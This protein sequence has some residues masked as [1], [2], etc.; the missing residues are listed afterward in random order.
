ML[1]FIQWCS[2][3]ITGSLLRNHSWWSSGKLFDAPGIELRLACEKQ[4]LFATDSKLSIF[5]ALN[6][7][8]GAEKDLITLKWLIHI[9]F[10]NNILC[11]P[12]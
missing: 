5:Y 11:T 2:R 3:I 4:T 1:G 12:S 10:I 9:I 7:E 6:E 8:A